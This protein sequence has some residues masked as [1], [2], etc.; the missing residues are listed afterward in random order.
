MKYA[1]N[2]PDGVQLSA[3][4]TA[5]GSAAASW[6][7]DSVTVAWIGVPLSTLLLA[8]AGAVISLTWVKTHRS[9]WVV[10][11]AGT[12]IGAVCAPL[13]A[14]GAGMDPEKAVALEKALAF[15]LALTVQVAVPALI[16]WIEKRGNS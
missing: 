3:V 14:W 10:V 4:L 9:W 2:L 11:G 16:K 7:A 6:S 8:F 12:L 5:A 1:V 15:V 13:L